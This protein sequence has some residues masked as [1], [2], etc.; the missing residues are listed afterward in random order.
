[1]VSEYGCADFFAGKMQCSKSH[2]TTACAGALKLCWDIGVSRAP[3][4]TLAC[5]QA[6]AIHLAA[7]LVLKGD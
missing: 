2:A 4:G 3:A 6:L 1:V 5:V 7:R